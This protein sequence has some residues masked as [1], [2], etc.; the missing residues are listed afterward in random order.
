MTLQELVKYLNDLEFEI[1][2]SDIIKQL[3]KNN[4]GSYILLDDDVEKWR[5][6]EFEKIAENDYKLSEI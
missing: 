6:L 4:K 3:E 5:V 1:D 2:E